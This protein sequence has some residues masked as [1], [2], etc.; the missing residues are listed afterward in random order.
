MEKQIKVDKE[1]ISYCGLYCAACG[2]Y[3]NGKCTGC[4]GNEKLSW[5]KI[6]KCS[7]DHGYHTCAECTMNVVD[8]KTYSNFISKLFGLIFRSDRKACIYRI[9]EIGEDAFAQEMK[10]KQMMTIKK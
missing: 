10:D 3:L 4:R 2:K 7:A 8:C 1:L 9:K 5:C 6:R